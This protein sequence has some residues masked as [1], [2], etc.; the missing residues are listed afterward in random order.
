MSHVI[1]T[2]AKSPEPPHPKGVPAPNRLEINDFVRPDNIEQFSLFVQA[3]SKLSIVL[4]IPPSLLIDCRTLV[5]L[6]NIPQQESLSYFGISGIH[7]RP[8]VQWEGAG[9]NQPVPEAD[10]GGYCVHGSV[11][12]PTWHRPYLALYEASIIT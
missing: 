1:I 6:Y 7:G 8:Y 10:F 3:L 4:Y 12:F 5:V 9:G 2:G 11:L